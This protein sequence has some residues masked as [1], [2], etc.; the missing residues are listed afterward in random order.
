M[1]EIVRIL[2][3]VFGLL[4][5]LHF[6]T[7]SAGSI[8]DTPDSIPILLLDEQIQM[9]STA[10]I[11]NMY[12]F[13][14]EDANIQFRVLKAKYGWHPLPYFMMGL[15]QWWRI[16]PDLDVTRYD[17]QFYAYMDTSLLLSERIYERGSTIE[18]A[19][20]MSATYAFI[21]R[22]ESE[23]KNWRKAALAG[24][25][26]LD[27][28]DEIRDNDEFSPELLFGDALF[29]YYREWVPENYPL[30]KP[31]LL[32]FEPGD[33]ELGIKQL[34]EVARNAF[35]TRTEAQY[36]LMRILAAEENRPYESLQIAEYL[37]TA[38][39]NNPYFHR[40]YARLLYHTGDYRKCEKESLEI[41]HRLDSAYNGYEFNS[42]RYA[43]FFL[44]EIYR[45]WNQLESAQK[46]YEM[47]VQY[48]DASG[49][50]ERGYTI[51]SLLNLGKI[52][53]RNREEDRAEY[54][55]KEVKKRAKR[56]DAVHKEA[57]EALREL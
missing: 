16:M 31:I 54:Y 10:A 26:A 8:P 44:G 35:Y 29:N 48:G 46:Y 39:P 17:E 7:L 42:A 19:F 57:R 21:G 9:E 43:T 50:A 38:F 47:A 18:G 49:D 55:F 27:Y 32:F 11:N 56:G 3:L 36:F 24:K 5:T 23:R 45:N 40:Y 2:V 34:K 22:L 25:R 20:F 12:N 51:Y 52:A 53:E 4:T 37:S 28:L 33:K 15:S 1:R 14:F 41:L 13:N 30:L 6:S